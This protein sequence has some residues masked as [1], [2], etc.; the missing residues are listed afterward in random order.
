MQ[1]SWNGKS[2]KW[3]V[4]MGPTKLTN[5][6]DDYLAKPVNGKVLEKMLVKWAIEG[7]LKRSALNR[8]VT[9]GDDIVS[10]D[11]ISAEFAVK[12]PA[13]ASLPLRRDD[14][15]PGQSQDGPVEPA[16]EDRFKYANESAFAK[17]SESEAAGTQRRADLEEQS[18]ALRDNKLLNMGQNPRLQYHCSTDDGE[19]HDI[20]SLAQPLPLTEENIGKF[21]DEQE[22]KEGSRAGSV[23]TSKLGYIDM[24]IGARTV[25]GEA[26]N[27]CE[28]SLL[29]HREPSLQHSAG[30]RDAV[31]GTAREVRYPKARPLMADVAARNGSD[32]TVTQA[33]SKR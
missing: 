1:E 24:P 32:R 30:L 12:I 6:K 21:V 17:S 19:H 4:I 27:E 9:T 15:T 10:N 22:K 7:K 29:V 18:I 11:S 13:A 25:E 8:S 5:N 2:L 26:G 16:K 31:Y 3:Y 28:S 23:G 20:L 33:D 14:S